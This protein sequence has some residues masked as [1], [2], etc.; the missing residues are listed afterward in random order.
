MNNLASLWEGDDAMEVVGEAEAFLAAALTV[1]RIP[2]PNYN[3]FQRAH[4]ATI[5]H[6]GF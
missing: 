6:H 1:D 5:G 2:D 3:H 4:N